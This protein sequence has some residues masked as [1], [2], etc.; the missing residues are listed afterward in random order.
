[1]TTAY[2]LKVLVTNKRLDIHTR[3]E[4]MI[5]AAETVPSIPSAIIE[6]D[7]LIGQY[8]T[9]ASDTLEPIVFRQAAAVATSKI[10]TN[11]SGFAQVDA[12]NT[13]TMS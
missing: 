7:Y 5:K 6:G 10:F 9:I 11:R 2:Y 8:S 3:S 1:M 13:N 12:D 4:C